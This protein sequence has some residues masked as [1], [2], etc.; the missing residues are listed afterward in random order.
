[1]K[2]RAAMLSLALLATPVLAETQADRDAI[3]ARFDKLIA[4]IS[5]GDMLAALE[6]SP[7]QMLEKMAADA[8]LTVDAMKEQ[9]G[10][11]S[12]MMKG[13]IEIEK[14]EY[15]LGAATF[16]NTGTREYA[17]IPV[18]I[19]MKTMGMTVTNTGEALALQDGDN[20]YVM[21][22]DSPEQAE[23]IKGIYPDLAEA[24]LPMMQTTMGQ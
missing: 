5:E 15:D 24:D 8:G 9:A 18:T 13:Q 4:S 19:E 3:T 6:L 14:F 17:R 23:I 7:P 1:M 21:Q 10:A 11:M 22:L 16:A 20:W 12:A 2:I